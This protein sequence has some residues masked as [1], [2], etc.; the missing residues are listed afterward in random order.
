MFWEVVFSLLAVSSAGCYGTTGHDA[1]ISPPQKSIPADGFRKKQLVVHVMSGQACGSE[2]DNESEQIFIEADN[3]WF[4]ARAYLGDIYEPGVKVKHL[5]PGESIE[6]QAELWLVAQQLG[7]DYEYTF[8]HEYHINLMGETAYDWREILM[9]SRMQPN[10]EA[11]S[12]D[13]SL[14]SLLFQLNEL[15]YQETKIISFNQ[16]QEVQEKVPLR[17]LIIGWGVI[18]TVMAGG[19]GSCVYMIHSIIQAL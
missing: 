15:T 1:S 18:G 3:Q 2:D 8:L 19:L 7:L 16:R 9:S 17:N 11:I 12:L 6:R 4:S 5:G 13:I 10:G 14:Y